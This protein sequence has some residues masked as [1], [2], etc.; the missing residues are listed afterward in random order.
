[1]RICILLA[2]WVAASAADQPA[3][4][5]ASTAGG[6]GFVTALTH[7]PAVLAAQERITAARRAEGAAG[8]LPDPMLGAGLSRTST[9]MDSWP[10]YGVAIEQPLPRWGERAAERAQAGAESAASV[11]EL[12]DVLGETAA[13]VATLLAEA[14]SARARSA[15]VD[16]QIS[17]SSSVRAA[18]ESR[19]A[20]GTGSSAELLAVTSRL[21]ALAVERA[22][23][24]RE[25]VDAEEEARGRLGL[26]ATAPLPP[27]AAPDHAA[28]VAD[29]VPGILAAR[30]REA[31]AAAMF[32]AARATRHPETAVGLRYEREE[33]PGDPMDTVGI[34]FRVSLPVWQGASRDLELA[35]SARQRAA[36]R[37]EAGWRFRIRTVL[38]RAERAAE[39]AAA[40]RTAARDTAGRLDAEYAAVIRAAAVQ[41]GVGLVQALDILDRLAEAERQV[42]EAEAAARLAEAGLWRLAPPSIPVPDPAAST[43]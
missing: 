36:R 1:M 14:G 6:D 30:A 19:V 33:Q 26:P 16:A 27:F 11:A 41:G 4:E 23:L 22:T 2:V 5:P 43:P 8:R 13:E 10:M 24:Q 42:I 18:A 21:A 7:A 3:A 29:R 31:G 37:D 35:A 17:R 40:A 39:V 28:I 25:A 9:A 34:E 20:S 38:G 15:L 12:M 32:E